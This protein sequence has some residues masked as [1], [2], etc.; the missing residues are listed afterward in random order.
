MTTNCLSCLKTF[1]QRRK[2][3]VYCSRHCQCKH[4]KSIN[5]IPGK[6]RLGSYKTCITCAKEFYVPNGRVAT[7]RYCSR[8]C[9][10]KAHLAKYFPVYGFKKTDRPPRRYKQVKINGVQW[11]EHRYIMTKHL[12]RPLESWEHVHHI[13]G[14]PS[15][16]RIENLKVLSNSEHSRIEFQERQSFLR[17]S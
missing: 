15:D 2:S 11:R 5:K 8:S 1:I 17:S 4:L 16:N 12:G 13:N 14:D 7:A 6:Q 3:N 9:L 10:A